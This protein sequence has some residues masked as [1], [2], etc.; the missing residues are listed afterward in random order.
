MVPRSSRDA[1]IYLNAAKGIGPWMGW[2]R[3]GLDLYL[4]SKASSS[5]SSTTSISSLLSALQSGGINDINPI[6]KSLM[7]YLYAG[8]LGYEVAQ[9]NAGYILRTKLITTS[10]PSSA[11]SSLSSAI[12]KELFAWELQPTSTSPSLSLPV[13]QVIDE[14]SSADEEKS[15]ERKKDIFQEKNNETIVLVNN[16]YSKNYLFNRLLFHQYL[17]SGKLHLQMDNIFYLGNCYFHNRC[18]FQYEL[19]R[20]S[21]MMNNKQKAISYYQ[22]SSYGK[23]PVA[24][25]YLGMMYHFNLMEDPTSITKEETQKNLIRANRYYEEVLKAEPTPNNQ[26]LFYFVRMLHSLL[27]WR[28]S[29]WTY[30]VHAVMDNVMRWFWT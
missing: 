5:S 22:L 3:R 7:C 11:D 18:G 21:M 8:E 20:N 26:Q 29:L 6:M 30:P 14:E 13:D 24:S 16:W 25:A 4:A 28:S 1:L 9:S 10:S 19:A 15:I 2:I 27:S 12:S 17:L 23:N